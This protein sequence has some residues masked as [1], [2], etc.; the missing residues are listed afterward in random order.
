[1]LVLT[2]GAQLD[3]LNLAAHTTK[4]AH[5]VKEVS[6]VFNT[7]LEL[8][9]PSPAAIR[10]SGAKEA[11]VFKLQAEAWDWNKSKRRDIMGVLTMDTRKLFTTGW[12]QVGVVGPLIF[13]FREP[14]VTSGHATGLQKMMKKQAADRKVRGEPPCGSVTLSFSF[15]PTSET[16]Q[17]MSDTFY[18]F[19]ADA[20]G[21]L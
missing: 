16:E 21:V 14:S 19:D 9:I 18:R 15:T 13:P 7:R 5:V 17:H 20:N 12:D 1:M 3:P 2:G 4:T 6:P 11:E 8:Q 10:A